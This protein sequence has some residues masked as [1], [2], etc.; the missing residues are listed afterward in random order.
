[1]KAE[2]AHAASTAPPTG[3][4][5]DLTDTATTDPATVSSST[6]EAV[7]L[8]TTSDAPH[9]RWTSTRKLA[10]GVGA[11]G[12]VAL[13]AGAVF[14]VQT[15]GLK[16]DAA[17]LCP[18]SPCADADAANAL[19]ARADT[20]ATMTNVS[21]GVGAAFVVGAVVLWFVGAPSDPTTQTDDVAFVPQISPTYAG[22]GFNA[23]F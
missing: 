9:S 11:A 8:D 22:V 20:R 18:T 4:A 7:P 15:Q 17:G 19:S 16:D 21:L 6:E 1:M 2:S 5:P 10:V 13:A 23:R 14:A 3:P 12:V